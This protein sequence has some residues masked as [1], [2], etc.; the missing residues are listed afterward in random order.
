MAAVQNLY[1]FFFISCVRLIVIQVWL[2][3]IHLRTKPSL[4]IFL[5]INS[6]I[7]F[8]EILI[9]EPDKNLRNP[10]MDEPILPV[11]TKNVESYTRVFTE[12]LRK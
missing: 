9:S 8:I 11:S 1:T 2:N 12:L 4:F 3:T 5:V 10:K 7:S 6:Y